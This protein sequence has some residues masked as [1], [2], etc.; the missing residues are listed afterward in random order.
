MKWKY[1]RY[2]VDKS[3]IRPARAR[4]ATGESLPPVDNCPWRGDTRWERS[5]LSTLNHLRH[6]TLGLFRFGPSQRVRNPRSAHNLASFRNVAIN[7]FRLAKTSNL[8]AAIRQNASR[9]D[10]LFARVGIMK[11]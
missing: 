11:L 7:L 4:L 3:R 2:A 6:L 10:R 8:A 5:S 1:G 9:V